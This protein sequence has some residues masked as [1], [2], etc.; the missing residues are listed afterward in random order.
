MCQCVFTTQQKYLIENK[1]YTV[2]TQV[3][4]NILHETRSH[5]SHPIL[6]CGVVCTIIV[7][8]QLATTSSS[9]EKQLSTMSDH[10][11]EL[12]DKMMRQSEELEVLR[13]N[14]VH[15]TQ[16]LSIVHM[17]NYMPQSMCT[18]YYVSNDV[19]ASKQINYTQGNSEIRKS[20][21]RW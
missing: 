2:C 6:H 21:P 1:H 20:W 5:S 9:Y 10:L 4:S 14:K 11:C 12:N 7:Q 8:D 13:R 16:P 17:C 15:Y 18:F 19:K 3:K